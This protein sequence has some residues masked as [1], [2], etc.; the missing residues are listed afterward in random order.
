[1]LHLL[2]AE[3]LSDEERRELRAYLEQLRQG[4]RHE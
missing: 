1:L 3:D 4:K 2:R